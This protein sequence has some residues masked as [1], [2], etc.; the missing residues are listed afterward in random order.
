[1]PYARKGGANRPVRWRLRVHTLE[2]DQRI[3]ICA[4]DYCKWTMNARIHS[5]NT[6][7]VNLKAASE[8]LGA[9]APRPPEQPDEAS[10]NAS[11]AVDKEGW[12]PVAGSNL[13]TRA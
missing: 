4:G 10:S 6:S 8:T 9:A 5:L 11:L 2:A 3:L 13:T 12:T 1:M 7:Q